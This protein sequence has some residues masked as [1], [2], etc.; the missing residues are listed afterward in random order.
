M[1]KGVWQ[2]LEGRVL[3]TTIETVPECGCR[4]GGREALVGI[5]CTRGGQGQGEV[6]LCVEDAVSGAGGG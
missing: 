2:S 1:S 5:S 3:M 6:L 4:T